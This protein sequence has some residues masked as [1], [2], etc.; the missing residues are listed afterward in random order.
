[1]DIWYS[2]NKVF[3]AASLVTLALSL[4]ILTVS[5][6]QTSGGMSGSS[7]GSPGTNA[8]QS[9]AP[10]SSQGSAG[11]STFGSA[12][13]GTAS[14]TGQSSTNA[15]GAQNGSNTQTQTGSLNSGQSVTGQSSSGSNQPGTTS[16]TQTGSS[17]NLNSLA[18]APAP[19]GAGLPALA[20]QTPATFNL[21]AAIQSTVQ[22]SSDLGIAE[23]NLA[24]DEAVVS[25]QAD[26]N[27]P[28]V[29][30]GATYTHLD[31]PIAITFGGTTIVVQPEN[32]QTF[33]ATGTL[34]LDISGQV[35]AATQAAQLQVMAD[36]FDVDRV[37]NGLI[38]NAQ[39]AY[40]DDLRAQHQVQVEQSAVTD[41][42]TQLKTAQTQ[43][44]GGIGQK[45]DVYRAS[46]QVS[47]AQQALLQAQNALALAQNNFNDI[48]GRDLA[49]PVVVQD[50]P[51]V[52]IGTTVTADGATTEVGAADFPESVF[53]TPPT[54]ELNEINVQNDIN[55]ALKARPELRADMVNVQAASKQIFLARVDDQPTLSLNATGDYY[56]VTDFQTPRH[57]LGIFAATINFPLFDGGLAHDRVRAARDERDES[58]I[59]YASDQTEVELQVRQ[60]YLNL[61]TSSNQ[62]AAAN[63][64]LQQAI[65]A[66]Q[67]AQVRYASGVGLYLEVTDAESALTEA[68]NSQVNAVYD[69]LISRAQ[70]QNALGTPNTQPTL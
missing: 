33:D 48:V 55:T 8:T 15:N 13:P 39:V 25:E 46:T 58:K 36:R 17:M 60:A 54:T 9:G 53:F 35:R 42:Q 5:S 14:G 19:Q 30:A 24:K 34:P 6:A 12:Q 61:Y 11:V 40:F 1:M 63:S 50:V 37:K 22:T 2:T 62:I 45:I 16:E 66:R 4:G 26:S 44:T 47:Q 21:G 65:A 27:K 20:S 51:G 57:S 29:N 23:K 52:T 59:T 41:T 69:Y 43:F 68:E 18:N 7:T 56:P 10:N 67:L 49:A 64:A 28:R 3:K 32:T 70:Y 31:S 38:L